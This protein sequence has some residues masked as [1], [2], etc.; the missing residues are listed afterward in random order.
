MHALL[1]VSPLLYSLYKKPAGPCD[2]GWLYQSGLSTGHLDLGRLD[3]GGVLRV[4]SQ[5]HGVCCAS[6]GGAP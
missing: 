1:L 5:D 6:K 4:L 2:L 3:H